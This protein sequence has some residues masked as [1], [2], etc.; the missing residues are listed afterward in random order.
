M[1]D[2]SELNYCNEYFIL[3]ILKSSNHIFKELDQ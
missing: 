3:V 1:N 2:I